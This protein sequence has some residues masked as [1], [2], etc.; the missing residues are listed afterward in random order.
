MHLNSDGIQDEMSDPNKN[1]FEFEMIMS[2][3]N[4]LLICFQ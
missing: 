3:P 2:N 1:L 4:K